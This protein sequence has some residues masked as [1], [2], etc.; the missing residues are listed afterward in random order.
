MRP[1]WGGAVFSCGC[2][3]FDD[4]RLAPPRIPPL[5]RMGLALMDAARLRRVVLSGFG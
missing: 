1:N 3:T 4:S 5:E 2:T